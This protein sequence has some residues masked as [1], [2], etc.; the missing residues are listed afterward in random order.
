MKWLVKWFSTPDETILDPFAGAGTTLQAAKELGRHAVGV[1]VEGRW[2]Q[3]AI[4]GLAQ[5]VLDIRV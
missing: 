5:E 2:C 4:D 1:E 3:Q